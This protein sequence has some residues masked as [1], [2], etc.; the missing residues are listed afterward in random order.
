[1]LAV[2]AVLGMMAAFAVPRF[3]YKQSDAHA[4]A[5]QNLA[6]S[7]RTSAFLAH[8]LSAAQGGPYSVLIQGRPIALEGGYPTAAAI[9]AA[10]VPIA[11]FTFAPGLWTRNGARE[12]LR[13]SVRY[14]P[15]MRPGA[16]PLVDLDTRG[17]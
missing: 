17:C 2:I 12:P 6:G 5:V 9:D 7:V 8:E 14:V 4:A 3:V 11:G 13:C 1:M 10:I 15:A 16:V